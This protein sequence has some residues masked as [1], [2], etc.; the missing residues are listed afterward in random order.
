[1]N[2]VA[3]I[4]INRERS[5]EHNAPIKETMHANPNAHA[6][7]CNLEM[8]GGICSLN[9]IAIPIKIK[10]IPTLQVPPPVSNREKSLN[11]GKYDAVTS[12]EPGMVNFIRLAC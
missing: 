2:T 11:D 1:M 8:L 4:A 7:R 10:P 12:I 3:G 9:T 5:S 6:S